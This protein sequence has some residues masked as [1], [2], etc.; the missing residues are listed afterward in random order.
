MVVH[1]ICKRKFSRIQSM[2]SRIFFNCFDIERFSQRLA[3][4]SSI[5]F[6]YGIGHP[7]LNLIKTDELHPNFSYLY[8]FL[9]SSSCQRIRT[10]RSQNKR[11]YRLMIRTKLTLQGSCLYHYI[12]PLFF[13]SVNQAKKSN[14]HY[15]MDI[16]YFFKRSS[17][18]TGNIQV[19]A[20]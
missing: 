9:F 5:F 12:L 4:K 11:K 6:C 16:F 15:M 18:R 1:I 8:I 14:R 19:L 7:S 3:H 2:W 10:I 20:R 13:H 17:S